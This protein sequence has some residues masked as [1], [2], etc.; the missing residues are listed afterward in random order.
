MRKMTC[1]VCPRGC[2]LT[3][4]S[5][6]DFKVSGHA[7][8][9]GAVYG[10]KESIAPSRTLTTTVQLSQGHLKRAPVKSSSDLPKEMLT[11]AMQQLATVHLTAPVRRGQVVLEDIFN[12]GVDIVVTRDID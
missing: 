1:I 6:N 10:R 3:V 2:E 4:D 5:E 11:G 7:C 9:R 12:S 8:P